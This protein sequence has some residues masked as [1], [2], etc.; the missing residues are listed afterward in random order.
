VSL[1]C[2]VL[3]A[4]SKENEGFPCDAKTRAT[5]VKANKKTRQKIKASFPLLP[6]FFLCKQGHHAY[7]NHPEHLHRVLL[8][9]WLTIFF[10]QS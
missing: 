4:N 7:Q 8:S 2:G 6:H 1:G 5:T 10:R 9:S 3:K